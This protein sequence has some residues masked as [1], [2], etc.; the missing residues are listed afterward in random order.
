M[1]GVANLEHRLHFLTDKNAQ[2]T[3]DNVALEE[4]LKRLEDSS[5]EVQRGSELEKQH[6][7]SLAVA[8]RTIQER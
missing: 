7:R 2:L 4:R 1:H 5:S 6:A 3:R 8:K